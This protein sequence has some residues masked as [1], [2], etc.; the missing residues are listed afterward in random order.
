MTVFAVVFG[1]LVGGVVWEVLDN[2]QQ[3]RLSAIFRQ[4]LEAELHK[5]AAEAYA[6]FDRQVDSISHL[7][8][9]LANHRQLAL[10]LEPI[11]W[12]PDD[13][14]RIREYRD[15]Q[16]PWLPP[17]DR[18]RP[19]VAPS[20]IALIDAT[21]RLREVYQ[22][23]EAQLPHG[24]WVD[25]APFLTETRGRGVFSV[26]DGQ[27][28]LLVSEPIEDQYYGRVGSLLMVVPVDTAFL[29][30]AVEETGESVITAI[31]D[32][33]TQT[34][35]A[36]SAPEAVVVGDTSEKLSRRFVLTYQSFQHYEGS[37]F[38]L[39]FTT[40][41]RQNYLRAV[42]GRVAK[43][44][45]NQRATAA[46]VFIL[47]YSLLFMVV[48]NRLS[49]AL[50][51]L[52]AFS[53][54]A[55]GFTQPARSGGNQLL[56]LED[57]MRDYIRRVR[58]A[59]EEMRER[60]ETEMQASAALTAAIMEASLDSIITIDQTGRI[61][62]FNPTA[63]RVFGYR[64]GQAVSRDITTL[65]ID[66]PYRQPFRNLLAGFLETGSGQV[67]DARAEMIA[68][69]RDGT[70]VPV[71]LAIKAIQLKGETLFTVYFRDVSARRRQE[72]EIRALAAFPRESPSPM[73]RINR[74]GV[75]SY[76]NEASEPL[77]GYWGCRRGQT[78]PLNWRV[79]IHDVLDSK[80]P[81][82]EEIRTE[83]ERFFSLLMAPIP[84]L[85]YVNVY[86]R[87]ITDARVAERQAR[88]RQT[89]LVHV[90]RL[91]SM[92]EMAT[93]IAHEL[94][95][96]LSA[97][98]NYANGSRRRL[99]SGRVSAEDLSEPLQQITRQASRAGEIIRRL[100][101]LVSR[102]PVQ[103]ETVHVN[104]L[105]NE[106]LSFVDYEIRK[107]GVRVETRLGEQ[108]D[109][110]RVDLVQIEQVILNL[111]R[112]AID[113]VIDRPAGK[114]LIRIATRRVPD[115]FVVIEVED[116]GPGLSAEVKSRLFEP[117]FSTKNTG[118]GMGLA[119]S[120]TIAEDHDGKISATD[121]EA[122]GAL[123]RLALPA[124]GASL[125]SKAAAS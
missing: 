120:Q 24:L 71:E 42:T 121:S 10:H 67:T 20:H 25:P 118:M 75:I 78:L 112:N 98:V 117:F 109:D 50:K 88:Q 45:R 92:G 101:A 106:V 2:F 73:L 68:V 36:S 8:R 29:A 74:V 17:P 13:G 115:G 41:V 4:E 47:V 21:G 16:P 94:N 59:R 81:R 99:E 54:S 104:T 65:I 70:R 76:A 11:H 33:D 60:H 49:R 93:G 39:Q 124:A 3:K 110:V 34:V 61:I 86:A 105:V 43:H 38:N 69:G 103:R 111:I 97:I 62:E 83:D 95:Q 44:A 22:M 58:D 51:R 91:S 52:A 116:N 57:W 102:Q 96:P 77:L 46:L 5:R 79:R 123:F 122:G 63:E 84:E 119:I 37:E 80:R 53:Q 64:R 14:Q 125:Q 108:L 114:R 55:L 90:C 30:A 82:E 26:V 66:E 23:A 31:L 40:L 9:L 19:S 72:A 35:L 48:S 87:E 7:A 107:F 27:T 85:D 18:W 56:V 32:G 28:L 113:A 89:E 1:L 6:D 12:Y 15:S 100:R